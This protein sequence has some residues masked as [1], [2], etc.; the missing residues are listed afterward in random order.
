MTEHD[1]DVIIKSF[2]NIFQPR[3]GILRDSKKKC[4]E[5]VKWSK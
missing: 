5:S 2:M 3:K 4:T 1:Q